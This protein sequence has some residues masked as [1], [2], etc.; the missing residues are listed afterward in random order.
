MS[1]VSQVEIRVGKR[2]ETQMKRE[3][4]S[5]RIAKRR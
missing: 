4:A 5:R 3:R 1:R 2:V